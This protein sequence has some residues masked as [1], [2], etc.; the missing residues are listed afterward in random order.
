MEDGW[1]ALKLDASQ[2]SS[3]SST[4]FVVAHL[5][6]SSEDLRMGRVIRAQ[7]RSHAIVRSSFYTFG[8]LADDMAS[9]SSRH[10]HT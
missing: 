1:A 10:I 3:L 4:V 8:G 9:Y 6:Y 2:K 5:T 7:R